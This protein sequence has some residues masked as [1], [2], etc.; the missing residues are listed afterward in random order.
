MNKKQVLWHIEALEEYSEWQNEDIKKA[1]KITKFIKEILKE[2]VLKGTGKPERLKYN[3]GYS[4]RIDEYNR[5]VYEI[6]D[7]ILVIISCKGHYED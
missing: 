7:N 3:A 1:N 2:G 6:E 4:R 5:L